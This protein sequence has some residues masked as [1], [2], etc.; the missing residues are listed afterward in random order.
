MA[1]F[2]VWKARRILW[3]AIVIVAAVAVLVYVFNVEEKQVS[4]SE[5]QPVE[6]IEDTAAIAQLEESEPLELA[7]MAENV[8]VR[9]VPTKFAE[10]RLERE[11]VRS[12][13]MELLQNAA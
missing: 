9:P 4:E 1:K 10:Y 5:Q 6:I 11:Q 2:Y 7:V 8:T 13:Q 12:R 3:N